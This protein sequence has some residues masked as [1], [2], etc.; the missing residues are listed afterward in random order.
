MGKRYIFISLLV[1]AIFSL[2]LAQWGSINLPTATF[3]LLPTRAWELMI[4]ALVAFLIMYRGHYIDALASKTAAVE[5]LGF[6]GLGLIFYAVF[7]FNDMMPFPG[8]WALLPTL[9]TALII[10]FVSSETA[11][12]RFLGS[13]LLVGVGLIS[14][15][16]YLWHQPLFVFARHRSLTRP[17]SLTFGILS[18]LSIALAYLSWRYVEQP[19]RKK[20]LISRR[21]IFSY[22]L[23]GMLFFILIGSV[24][25]LSKGFTHQR[26]SQDLLKPVLKV[27]TFRRERLKL[28]RLGECQFPKNSGGGIKDFINKWN[29]Y[30][31]S[32]SDGYSKLPVAVVGDSLSADLVVS[33]KQSGFLPMQISGDGCSLTPSL[34]Q[35][36][37]AILFSTLGNRIKDDKRIKY[38]V[39]YNRYKWHELSLPNLKEAIDYWSGFGKKLIFFTAMPE[40]ANFNKTILRRA[41]PD[42]FLKL[43]KY[44]ERKEVYDYLKSRDVHI[45][46]TSSVFCNSLEHCL[47][48]DDE[49]NLLLTDGRHLTKQGAIRFGKKLLKVD[50]VFRGLTGKK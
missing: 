9:G 20:G 15:S 17:D 3:F 16:A 45:V 49:G 31:D 21:R 29:C 47:Y 41:D 25:Y 7:S 33:L 44:S 39:L 1:I 5:V 4:G 22:S 18:A 35:K 8:V 19:F 2:A 36:E 38:I 46:S 34:M 12:G 43:V 40:F 23:A 6:L 13:K 30:D 48:H 11:V 26:F 37:C 28:I 24:G 32:Y 50:P 27:K 42:P 14:Y 10:L